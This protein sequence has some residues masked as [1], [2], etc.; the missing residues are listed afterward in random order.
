[1]SEGVDMTETVSQASAELPQTGTQAEPKPSASAPALAPPPVAKLQRAH[2]AELLPPPPGVVSKRDRPKFAAPPLGN[3]QASPAAQSSIEQGGPLP[4]GES[5]AA[6]PMQEALDADHDQ[7]M[8]APSAQA[9]AEPELERSGQEAPLAPE[10][11]T[12]AKQAHQDALPVESIKSSKRG[13]WFA[14][15]GLLV[16][17]GLTWWQ[18]GA[19]N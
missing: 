6:Q 16:L 11:P 18:L 10:Q 15:I 2:K 7:G 1:M 9:P 13:L 4:S 3:A 14:L 19:S 8:E 12:L 17:A 5:T